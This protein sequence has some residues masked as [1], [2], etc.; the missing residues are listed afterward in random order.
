VPAAVI[1]RGPVVRWGNVHA[2]S[3]RLNSL[4]SGLALLDVGEEAVGVHPEI[5]PPSRPAGLSKGVPVNPDPWV[6]A[7]AQFAG[8]VPDGEVR[9]PHVCLLR[10]RR[11]RR[12][13]VADR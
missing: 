3:L 12:R 1:G 5:R 4:R 8:F 2:R 11:G 7:P 6:A 9:V 13:Q 10:K